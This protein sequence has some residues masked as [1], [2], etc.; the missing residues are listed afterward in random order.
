[1]KSMKKLL[2]ILIAMLA[3]LPMRAQMQAETRYLGSRKV[4]ALGVKGGVLLPEYY[5]R[6]RP[7]LNSLTDTTMSNR[8]RPIFG[9]QAEIPMDGDWYLVP[10]LLYLQRG[11]NTLEF[12]N[13]PTSQSMSYSAKVNY[14][15]LRAS[16]MYVAPLHSAVKPYAFA[17]VN[18]GFVMPYIHIDSLPFTK[19]DSLVLNLSGSFMMGNDSVPVNKSNMAPFDI[20]LFG[21]VGFRATLD[22]A[23]FSLV[24]KLEAAYNLGLLNTFSRA[25]LDAQAPAVN[26]GVGGNTLYHLNSRKNRGL[27]VTFSLVL[28]L[29]FNEGDACSRWS[30]EVYHTSRR[31]HWSF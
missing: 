23:R 14:F 12:T 4:V 11:E 29:K 1:M 21:G 24:M 8:L 22:F 18:V 27:E 7:D 2:M 3:V 19:G 20:G 10:E 25:E 28:P 16:M 17:G 31:G 30:N 13:A 9:V 15:D 5:Y 6:G 26:L